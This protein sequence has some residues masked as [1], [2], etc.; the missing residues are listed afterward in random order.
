[1]KLNE[2]KMIEIPSAYGEVMKE[3]FIKWIKSATTSRNKIEVGMGLMSQK[4]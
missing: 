3:L 1:M 2:K 4:S